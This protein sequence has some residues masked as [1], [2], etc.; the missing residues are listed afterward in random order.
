MEVLSF[1]LW[2]SAFKA[3]PT[4]QKPQGGPEPLPVK[5]LTY[6]LGNGLLILSHDFPVK[7]VETGWY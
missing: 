3:L 6:H 2:V 1:N 5:T 7:E 4:V